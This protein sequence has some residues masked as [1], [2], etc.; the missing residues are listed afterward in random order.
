MMSYNWSNQTLEDCGILRDAIIQLVIGQLLST[1]N[2]QAWQLID[3]LASLVFDIL[4]SNDPVALKRGHHIIRMS[5]KFFVMTPIHNINEESSQH[6]HIFISSS[7]LSALVMLYLSLDKVKKHVAD[8]SIHR[9]I[10]SLMSTDLYM[11]RYSECARLILVFCKLLRRDVGLKDPLYRFCRGSI[12]D[13]V[14]AIGITKCKK[15]V[16]N[17]LLE[18]N[19]NKEVTNFKVWRHFTM[20]MREEARGGNKEESYE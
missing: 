3:D 20:R 15:N 8:E 6:F 16:A 17:E 19:D 1:N 18:L 13:I 2:P 10:N 5:K 11:K 12:M 4:R 14:E 9:F 7:V